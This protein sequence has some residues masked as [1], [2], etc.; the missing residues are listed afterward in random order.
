[1]SL[2]AYSEG[3]NIPNSSIASTT[4]QP[5]TNVFSLHELVKETDCKKTQKNPKLALQT[6]V[7]KEEPSCKLNN[8]TKHFTCLIGI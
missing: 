1:M 4:L 2:L 5:F 7:P 6:N 3:Y 8:H